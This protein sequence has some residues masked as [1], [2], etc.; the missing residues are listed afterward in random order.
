MIKPIT[1]NALLTFLHDEGYFPEQSY[2]NIDIY[3]L[4][5]VNENGE[6]I[7]DNKFCAEIRIDYDTTNKES[8]KLHFSLI[9]ARNGEPLTFLTINKI[10]GLAW[11]R[12]C[13]IN[14]CDSNNHI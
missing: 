14:F 9:K 10:L 7:E 3:N 8:K 2:M 11:P 12:D 4:A 5:D 13:S 1:Y 6:I